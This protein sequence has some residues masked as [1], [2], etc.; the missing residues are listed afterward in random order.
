MS[1]KT[2]FDR[3]DRS[4]A[5]R[6]KKYYRQLRPGLTAE[7][8]AEFEAFVGHAFPERFRAL[9]RWRDGQSDPLESLDSNRYFMPSAE[10]KQTWEMLTSFQEN[11]QWGPGH[12]QWWHRGWIPFLHNGAGSHLCLDLHGSFTGTAGQVIE[13]WNH[14]DDRPIVAPSFEVWLD[15][16]VDTLERGGGYVEHGTFVIG[17]PH[18]PGY[19]IR[20]DPKK[21]PRGKP[22]KPRLPRKPS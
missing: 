11:G 12:P 2:L 19:P 20:G 17:D 9:Y 15:H 18:V 16:V 10:A 3:L 6:R 21:E 8:L 13:F 1:A 5:R 7:Q 14:F 4:L 22:L